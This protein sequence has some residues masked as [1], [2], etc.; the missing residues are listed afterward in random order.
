LR[1]RFFFSLRFIVSLIGGTV[2]HVI[3]LVGENR[4]QGAEHSISLHRTASLA[5]SGSR[6]FLHLVE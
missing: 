3:G 5:R 6:L 2:V 1:W 4:P